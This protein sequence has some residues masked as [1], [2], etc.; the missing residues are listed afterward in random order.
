MP[1]AA[2][3]ADLPR[4]LDG[5]QHLRALAAIGV[6]LFHAAE[7]S[8]LHFTIGAAGVDVFFV[9]SG[10]IMWIITAGRPVTP[11]AFLRERILRIVPLYWLATA[12]MVFGALAGLC[13]PTPATTSKSSSI[14]TS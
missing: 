6:V 14:K 5:I 13:T 3:P 8:G 11:N 4:R 9:I 1:S 10:F 12:V 2:P 7:R